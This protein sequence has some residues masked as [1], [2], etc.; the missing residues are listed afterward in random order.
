MRKSEQRFKK[1]SDLVIWISGFIPEEVNSRYTIFM[2]KPKRLVWLKYLGGGVGRKNR[3]WSQRVKGELGGMI[4]QEV[5]FKDCIRAVTFTANELGVRVRVRVDMVWLRF[6]RT[7]T[8]PLIFCIWIH[9]TG[10]KVEAERPV[11]WP[12]FEE[13]NTSRASEKLPASGR[14]NI[15]GGV[16]GGGSQKWLQEF[17]F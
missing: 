7:L 4:T 9:C 8:P 14:A 15:E 11:R 5:Q 3:K 16:G 6:R 2:V 13:G 17:L 10:L 12:L 1:V